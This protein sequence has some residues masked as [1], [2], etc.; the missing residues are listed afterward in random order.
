MG[1]PHP[2]AGPTGAAGFV[3]APVETMMMH[4]CSSADAPAAGACH[5]APPCATAAPMGFEGSE[6]RLEIDFFAKSAP[7]AGEIN[8]KG[9]RAIARPQLDA[10]L[11]LAT[12]E[13]VS[14]RRAE[15]FDAY[16]LSE[17]SLFVYTSKM[18]IKTCGTTGLLNAVPEILRLAKTVGLAPRRC[19][20]SRASY[21]FPEAQLA[22]HRSF[23]EESMFLEQHFGALGGGGHAYVLGDAL[24]AGLRWHVY[25]AE[26]KVSAAELEPTRTLEV[27]MT[28][29]PRDVAGDF[30][31][32]AESLTAAQ[33]TER[34]GIR[35]LFPAAVIDDFSFEPC[36][37]SMNGMDGEG[38][39]TIHVTPEEGFSYASVELSG[40]PADAY[41]PADMVRRI[42]QT[43]RPAAAAVSKSGDGP[44]D[45]LWRT[46]LD[47]QEY[48]G[49]TPVE[50]TIQCGGSVRFQ[51]LVEVC[52]EPAVAGVGTKKR[53][54]AEAPASPLSVFGGAPSEP[55][56][57]GASSDSEEPCPKRSRLDA[58]PV[59]A[60]CAGDGDGAASAVMTSFGAVPLLCS[61]PSAIDEYC[62]ELIS[63]GRATADDTETFMVMDLGIVLRRWRFWR[64]A[65][66]RVEPHYA[67][68]CNNDPALLSLLASLGTGFDCAS[69]AELDAVLAMGVP[70]ERIVYAN[71][72]KMPKHIKHAKRVRVPLTT[73]D[74][75]SE[76]HKLAAHF[77]E[78]RLLLRIRADDPNARCPLGDKYG[79]EESEIVPL[80]DEARRL[81]LTVA[82]I[83]F[84][85]GSGASDP[86]S[87]RTAVRLG[88][89]A[90]D[91]AVRAG[92]SPYIL[93]VGGGFSGGGVGTDDVEGVLVADVAPLMN[94]ALEEYFP[95]AEGVQVIAE[96]GRYFAEAAVSLAGRIFGRRVR[97]DQPDTHAYWIGDGLYGSMN[98]LLY[99]H[100]VL[101]ARALGT[102]PQAAARLA[103]AERKKTTVFGP[104]CDGL[105]TI[106]RGADLPEMQVGDWLMFPN[107]GAYTTS[108]GS[109]FN[110]FNH[111]EAPTFYVVSEND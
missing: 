69:P 4:A 18:V 6:K 7:G 70:P 5:S 39:C 11:R 83:A 43:F 10:M 75:E 72:C 53:E 44:L 86:A 50:Q 48:T 41:E 12:C 52:S 57:H 29:L 56:E 107:M 106:Q 104:T 65:L 77:P 80:L 68:K 93:D 14:V 3:A 23:D 2:G 82:G 47:I 102:T 111:L 89:E 103:L 15:A 63:S 66:P 90:F 51:T 94:A 85:V 71:C 1:V 60:I 19:K 16:V 32:T 105:D 97:N 36:G 9:L 34:S 98:C 42:L 21:L 26:A 37:Y 78:S 30:F 87:F 88:R 108:A 74:N 99:D 31:R 54:K 61:K 81:G 59:G 95:E 84:H 109:A 22:P 101:T 35:A 49:T 33:V 40:Y 58:L 91:A 45:S 20:Y 73:F 64:R 100:A 25:C 62:A 27:C 79:A 13:I 38:F 17:S 28:G 24:R 55:S 96:P 92:H 110:G 67:V 76:L 8:E 46:E